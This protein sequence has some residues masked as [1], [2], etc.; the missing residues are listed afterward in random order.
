[1]DPGTV[2]IDITN[3]ASP[4]IVG[5]VDT[6]ADASGVAVAGDYAY[7]ADDFSGLRVVDIANPESPVIVGSVDNVDYPEYTDNVSVANGYAYVTSSEGV[8][9][10]IDIDL[11]G[12]G[13]EAG[14]S[15]EE[16]ALVMEKLRDLGYVA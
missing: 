4:A 6:P 12:G 3:P 5:S 15:D 1:M 8:L 2:M 16:E 11:S 9:Q 7:V 10:A 13:M 14:V